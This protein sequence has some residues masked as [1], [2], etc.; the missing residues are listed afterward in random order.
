MK[1]GLLAAVF[2]AI[3]ALGG[4]A[5]GAMTLS[6]KYSATIKAPKA[7]AGKWTIDFLKGGKYRVTD[8]GKLAV[9]GNSTI[10]G[11][12]LTVKDTGGPG[13]CKSA[14]VYT[15]KLTGKTLTFT[16]V[17]DKCAGRVG[18]LKYPFTKG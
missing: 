18:V 2:I 13:K 12:R 1:K 14:G 5:L 8:N 9:K 6:G 11:H 3:L 15:F 4:S 7:I 16:K 17:H 10:T